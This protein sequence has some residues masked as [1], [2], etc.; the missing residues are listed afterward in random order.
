MEEEVENENENTMVAN[1]DDVVPAEPEFGVYEVYY[2][3][4]KNVT[5]AKYGT[6]VEHIEPIEAVNGAYPDGWPYDNV[7]YIDDE[8]DLNKVTKPGYKS[9]TTDKDVIIVTPEYD[10][11][12]V[13]YDVLKNTIDDNETE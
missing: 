12:D 7:I 11:E 2:D 5:E 10:V 3:V 4:L 6:I 8:N 1:D 13:Y 9:V